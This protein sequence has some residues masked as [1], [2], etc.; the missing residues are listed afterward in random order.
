MAGGLIAAL[1]LSGCGSTTSSPPGSS[2]GETVT[3]S[4]ATSVGSA[5][6]PDAAS[7]TPGGQDSES[8]RQQIPTDAVAAQEFGPEA[9]V[10]TTGRVLGD[11]GYDVTGHC[12]GGTEVSYRVLLDGETVVSGSLLCGAE[13][14]NTGLLQGDAGEVQVNV[15]GVDMNGIRGFVA[16]VPASAD[17]GETAPPG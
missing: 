9:Q 15:E 12:S 4:T 10:G 6:S 11:Q 8:A 16:L 1:A 7:P 2:A 17:E 5:S 14:R 3:A 13:Q